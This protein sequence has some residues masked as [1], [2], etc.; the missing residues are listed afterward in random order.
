MY[1]G[2]FGWTSSLAQNGKWA[3]RARFVHG[4]VEVYRNEIIFRDEEKKPIFL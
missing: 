3:N 2:H 4:M 1:L